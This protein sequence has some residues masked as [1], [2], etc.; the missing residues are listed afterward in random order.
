MNKGF[1][2]SKFR[3]NVIGINQKVPVLKGKWVNYINLDNAASTPALKPILNH[4]EDFLAYY[5]GVHRGTGF[6]S[7]K[8]SHIY[9]Q[10]HENIGHFVGADMD[11][12][13]VIMV[14]NTTEAINKLSYRLAFLRG[15]IVLATL[16][17]HHSNDL[18]WRNKALVKYVNIDQQGLLNMNDLEN[19]LKAYYPRVKLVAV[20]GA[21]N[22]TGHINDIHKIAEL[23]HQYKAKILVDAAQLIAHKPIDVKP[24]HDPKHIDYLAFSGHKIYAPFG[25]GVLI[26]PKETFSKGAPEYV[27]GGTVSMVTLDK[28]YWSKLPNREE[29]G[30]PNVVGTY[31]LSKTLEYLKSLNM[32][33]IEHY[34]QDLTIYALKKLQ[35]VPSII[36]YGTTPRVGVISFN[37]ED[38]HHSLVGSI[39]CYE[40][41]IGLRTG[42]FCAQPYVRKLLGE[43]VVEDHLKY[44]ENNNINVIPGMVR[45]SIGAYNTKEE[46]DYLVEW[47]KQISLKK[48]TFKRKYKFN[49]A[50][51]TY[52]PQGN[53]N[54]RL[55]QRLITSE[56]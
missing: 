45:I 25:S 29:A 31:A 39:L 17:E 3:K 41:G 18:P 53:E 40:A 12:N 23:A 9:E 54:F 56:N 8:S 2:V 55:L 52:I 13:T 32:K 43:N 49:P 35:E 44:Y 38:I 20:C 5:S 6:K 36:I 47:L 51:S 34:E 15:D 4:I 42:C 14:K 48:N 10:C 21:S 24:N 50:L 37:I 28:V 30:S 33:Q 19:Q 26:G 1:N 16:M 7:L 11:K 46:I 22:V 27:G